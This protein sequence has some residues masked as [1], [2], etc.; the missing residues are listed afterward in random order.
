MPLTLPERLG[1]AFLVLFAAGL[2]MGVPVVGMANSGDFERLL[3][4][5]GLGYAGQDFEAKYFH[6]VVPT[7]AY[8]ALTKGIYG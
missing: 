1:I 4:W 8:R 3:M 6:W 5:G 7:F 2:I